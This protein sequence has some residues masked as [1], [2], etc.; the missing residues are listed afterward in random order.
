MIFC[1]AQNIS[2]LAIWSDL[3]SQ[4]G[5]WEV[6]AK[7]LGKGTW[8]RVPPSSE[9]DHHVTKWNWVECGNL[10]SASTPSPGLKPRGGFK[11]LRL[12]P[13]RGLAVC[14]AF[15]ILDL[16]FVLFFE[17]SE[18]WLLRMQL[19]WDLLCQSIDKFNKRASVTITFCW[20]HDFKN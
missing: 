7:T 2:F 8:R 11:K 16:S 9:G 14:S 19:S 15:C 12:Q 10:W 6:W 4:M 1:G 5:G 20:K 13:P 3:G 18:I 17:H